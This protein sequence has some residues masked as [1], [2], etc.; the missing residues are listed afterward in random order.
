MRRSYSLLL[1][2]ALCATGALAGFPDED[3]QNHQYTGPEKDDIQ[4]LEVRETPPMGSQ[5]PL[6]A[7]VT[8]HS[9]FFLDRLAIQCTLYDQQ[10]YRL[11]K[12]L[13]FQSSPLLGFGNRKLGMPPGATGEVGLYTTDYRWTKGDGKYRYDCQVYGVR[14]SE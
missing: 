8:N 3:L 10:G 7:K 4:L 2:L 5:R 14:G 1:S 9:K 12:D 13:V 6:V 11:F